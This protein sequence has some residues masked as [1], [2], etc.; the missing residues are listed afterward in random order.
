MNQVFR[1]SA[2]S[3]SAVLFL[4]LCYWAGATQSLATDSDTLI[5]LYIAMTLVGL[6]A[7]GFFPNIRSEKNSILLIVALAI[8]A[9]LMMAGFPASDDVNRY[10]WEGK[11]ILAGESP[12]SNKADSE[13]WLTYRDQFWEDMNHK[14]KQTIYPPLALIAFAGLNLISSQLWL[15]KLAFGFLDLGNLLLVIYLLKS[16]K[17]PVRSSIIYALSP[18]TVISFSGEAHFDSL[19]LFFLLAAL[20]FFDRKK[21]ALGWLLLGLS[22]QIKIISVLIIP[23]LFWNYK[24][25]KIIWLIVPIVVPSLLFWKDLQTLLFGIMHFG[26]TMSHNGSINHLFIEF[27]G[28]REVASKLSLLILGFVIAITALKSTDLL[29]GSFIT[30]GALILLSPTIHYWYFSWVLPFIVFF[31]SL[32]WMLLLTLSGF[33]F[34]AWLQFGSSGTWRQ[35]IGYLWLQWIPFYIIWIPEFVCGIRKILKPSKKY[36]AKTISVVIPTLNEIANL[37]ACLRSLQSSDIQIKEIIVVDGGS[38]DGTTSLAKDFPFILLTAK[39]GRGYQIA[40][41]VKHCTSDVI[42]V[43]HADAVVSSGLAGSILDCFRRNPLVIGGAVGQRFSGNCKGAVL[44]L[45]ELLNDFR[46]KFQGN[47]FGDQGQFFKKE[48]LQEL[49]GFPEIPL[50]EDVELSSRL[51]TGGD[52]VLL[53]STLVGS[54]RRWE[55]DRSLA[56]IFQVLSLVLRYK[57][58]RVFGRDPTDKLF[59]E[60]YN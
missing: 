14:D 31:P 29:K 59:R 12:Y 35:P 1:L 25:L 22:V 26:S 11:L 56:R 45:I 46:A 3:V 4:I 17:Q 39:K 13:E 47:S 21:L 33:Y 53:N 34:S 48:A 23:L 7:W 40:E 51:K 52:L 16:R 30:F 54:A 37:S 42:L 38:N 58:H 36:P 2:F 5:S 6:A 20:L 27:F 49:G 55:K 18:V 28:S 32:A 50:M 10:V 57:F 19:Y 15:Y 60:Y 8:L 24:N 44:V 9:R 41:G 43:L